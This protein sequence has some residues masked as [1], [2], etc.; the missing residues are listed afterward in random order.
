MAFL[1]G[2][3]VCHGCGGLA[4]HYAFGGRT[5]GSPV[6]YGTIYVVIGL[7]FAAAFTAAVAVFPKPILGVLLVFEA[8]ALMR[9]VRDVV[10]KKRELF[11]ALLVG[12]IAA[13]SQFGFLIGLLLG[14]ALCY[15]WHPRELAQDDQLTLSLP[16]E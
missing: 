4:G 12:V 6:I 14:V 16:S 5:G 11:I 3:P 13:N 1:G 10:G 7:F 15:L 9:L 8:V 2:V